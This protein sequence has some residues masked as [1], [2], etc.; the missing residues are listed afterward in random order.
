[1]IFLHHALGGRPCPVF[2]DGTQT[3]GFS[4]VGDV[5]PVIAESVLN[6]QARNETFNIGAGE[7]CSVNELAELVQEALGRRVGIGDLPPRAEARHVACDH[8][9]ADR[10]F[11]RRPVVGLRE[12]IR[13][14]AD[15]ARTVER[16]PARPTRRVEITKGLPPSWA[17]ELEHS[18]Y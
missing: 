6:P 18:G 2:G 1:A 16:R 17:R 3:R 10:V 14:M 9:K 4:Y 13:R 11:G 8:A 5:A 12:G 15:W 7:T